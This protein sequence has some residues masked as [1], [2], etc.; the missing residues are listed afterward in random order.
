[1]LGGPAPYPYLVEPAHM[2]E[3][4]KVGFRLNAAAEERK[5]MACGCGEPIGDGCGD[6]GRAHFS[7]EPPIHDRERLSGLRLKQKHHGH[8]SWDSLLSIGWIEA[9]E[10]EAHSLVR[11]C[12]HDPQVTLPLLDGQDIPYGLQCA[13]GREGQHGLFHSRDQVFPPEHLLH[14]RFVEMHDWHGRILH[15]GLPRS[16][17]ATGCTPSSRAS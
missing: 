7:N 3:G 9:D 5:N 10:F 4:L 1:M 11:D 15:F 12:G 8:M 14:V 6:S 16:S 2:P 13:S 17:A